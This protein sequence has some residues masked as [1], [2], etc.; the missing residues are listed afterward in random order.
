MARASDIK[1]TIAEQRV[2]SSST[3]HPPP[4]AATSSAVRHGTLQWIKNEALIPITFAF[5]SAF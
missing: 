1:N 5:V 4:H 3:H 2:S